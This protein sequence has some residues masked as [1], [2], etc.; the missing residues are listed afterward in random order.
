MA[1]ITRIE[2][3]PAVQKALKD[4]AELVGLH[5]QQLAAQ[6]P[7]VARAAD[8]SV[9]APTRSPALAPSPQKTPR[10]AFFSCR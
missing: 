10:R 2:A 1:Y 9:R 3:R 5:K 6:V 7:A 8:V 4:E